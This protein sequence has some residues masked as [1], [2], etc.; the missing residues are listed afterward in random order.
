MARH[1]VVPLLTSR[2]D[3]AARALAAAFMN[4]P[5][6]SY[7]FPDPDARARL[8]PPHFGALLRYGLMAGEVLTS[9]EPGGG[10][11]VWMPPDAAPTDEMFVESGLARLGDLLGDDAARRFGSVIEF[12]E[13]LHKVSMPEPHWYVMVVGVAPAFQGQGLGRALLQPML[14]RADFDGVPCYLETTQ[15]KNVTFYQRLGFRV[16]REEVEPG[17][18]LRIW[19]F[20]R[21]HGRE[22][23]SR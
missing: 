18:G 6:Q 3:E 14:D 12:V 2:L 1:Q 22:N 19:T 4:D 20:R 11:S 10:A 5:L 17:S 7:T 15:P 13:P 8:S 21:D 16:L 23:T 9:A